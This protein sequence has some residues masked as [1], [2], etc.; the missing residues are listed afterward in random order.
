MNQSQAIDRMF[1]LAP[2][3]MGSAILET[4]EAFRDQVVMSAAIVATSVVAIDSDVDSDVETTFDPVSCE[5]LR[6]LSEGFIKA[7]SELCPM[8][9]TPLH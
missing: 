2:I 7:Y 8:L 1:A 5:R 3:V 6:I 4:S 9:A